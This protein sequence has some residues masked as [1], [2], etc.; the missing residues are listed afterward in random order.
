MVYTNTVTDYDEFLK[1]FF[2]NERGLLVLK[3]NDNPLDNRW[4]SVP[5][6]TNNRRSREGVK[7]KSHNPLLVK[8]YYEVLD[9]GIGGVMILGVVYDWHFP[10]I[11]Q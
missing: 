11:Y 2:L 1:L 4:L 3:G 10:N 6:K 7:I 5:W 9:N 8:E